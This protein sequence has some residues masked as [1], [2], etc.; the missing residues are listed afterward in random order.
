MANHFIQG[1]P[2][3]IEIKILN[4]KSVRGLNLTLLQ[5]A[6]FKEFFIFYQRHFKIEISV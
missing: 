6:Y 3:T 1:F 4:E 2:L 5:Q